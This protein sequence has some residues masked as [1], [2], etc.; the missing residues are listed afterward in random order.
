MSRQIT[1]TP[2]FLVKRK[3][4]CENSRF[5]VF[6]DELACQDRPSAPDYLVVAP[7]Q[8][9]G[10]L[11]SGVAVLPICDDKIGLINAYRHAIQGDSWEIPRGFIEEGE[12]APVSA[13]RE[14]EEETGLSCDPG[15]IKFLAF[16]TPDAGVLA[17]R[18]QVY[19]A[20]RCS[21]IRPYI[22]TELGHREFRL[23]DRADVETR[24]ST[25]EIQD[26]CTLV[27]CYR[28]VNLSQTPQLS[29]V[30]RPLGG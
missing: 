14:L 12:S 3:L 15:E 10:N 19:V 5:S 13:L 18:V 22:S 16:V 2:P 25:S 30:T 1:V 21:R 20:L 9:A 24:M 29:T 17:A 23:F 8:F 26:P 27:A 7:K 11:V 28:Y 4:V 6:F